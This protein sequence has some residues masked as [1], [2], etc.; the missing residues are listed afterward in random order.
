MSALGARTF[1]RSGVFA[2][3]LLSG[4]LIACSR[5]NQNVALLTPTLVPVDVGD[6][7]FLSGEPCGPP[8]FWGITPGTTTEAEVRQ[9]LEDQELLER[10]R[11][12]NNEAEGAGRGITCRGVMV[13]DFLTG[14]DIVAGIG[15]RP[16]ESITLEQVIARYGTPD[17]VLVTP[18]GLPEY[19]QSIAMSIYY[20]DI[21]AF[22]SLGEQESM[23]FV[24]KPQIQLVN[25]AYSES[26]DYETVRQYGS[27]W[28]GF[29]EY[30]VQSR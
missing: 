21:F 1:L 5:S 30:V 29:G 11:D 18:G 22:L 12:F 26:H 23:T 16:S 8:C 27:A 13:V 15:F 3:F 6:G 4:G 24:V 14:T 19:E 7:G 25:I 17:A 28:H 9:V 10:C 20:D 2:V